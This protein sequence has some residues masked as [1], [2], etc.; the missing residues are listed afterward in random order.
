MDLT[1]RW[2]VRRPSTKDVVV[3]FRIANAFVSPTGCMAHGDI[4]FYSAQV[5]AGAIIDHEVARETYEVVPEELL[6]DEITMV[7]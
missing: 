2:I 4:T 5:L 3:W 7:P 1:E 6:I